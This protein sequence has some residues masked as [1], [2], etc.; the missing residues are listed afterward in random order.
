MPW[1]GSYHKNKHNKNDLS[2][3]KKK[4]SKCL[5]LVGFENWA[6][7]AAK[8][9]FLTFMMPGILPCLVKTLP[10][11]R[12]KSHRKQ[13]T[14][15]LLI[16]ST[17]RTSHRHTGCKRAGLLDCIRYKT[18]NKRHL[19]GSPKQHVLFL[20]DSL[21]NKRLLTPW[22]LL[23]RVFS[24]S[25]KRTTEISNFVLATFEMSASPFIVSWSNQLHWGSTNYGWPYWLQA[26][27]VVL[28]SPYI[29]FYNDLC[30]YSCNAQAFEAW[31]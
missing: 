11:A 26:R 3:L 25:I 27:V 31:I 18:I 12:F 20:T 23:L 7:S 16:L 28:C 1:A 22:Y 15:T 9:M 10:I 5:G 17:T 14:Q 29:P 4:Y 13:A 30:L 19:K 6:N 21:A 8:L 24:L 2:N